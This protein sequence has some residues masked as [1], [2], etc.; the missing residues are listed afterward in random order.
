M[1]RTVKQILS[2]DTAKTCY[3][4]FFFCCDVSPWDE[5]VGSCDR[6][7]LLPCFADD[8]ACEDFK[9]V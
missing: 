8:L 2:R 1:E 9:P 3:D 7:S 4:C 6:G 5:T